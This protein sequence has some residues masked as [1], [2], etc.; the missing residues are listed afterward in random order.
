M[1]AK[2][3]KGFFD[4]VIAGEFSYLFHPDFWTPIKDK[5]APILRKLYGA[6][7]EFEPLT[8]DQKLEEDGVVEADLSANSEE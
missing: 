4:A 8:P 5:D 6:N 7:L 1:K 3:R 2:S